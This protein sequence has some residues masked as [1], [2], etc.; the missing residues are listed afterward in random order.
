M[1]SPGTVTKREKEER[2]G[3]L[4]RRDRGTKKNIGTKGIQGQSNNKSV[5][6]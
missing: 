2:N 3:R 6:E 1:A 4:G 5:T